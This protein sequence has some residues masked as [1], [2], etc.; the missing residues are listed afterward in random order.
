MVDLHLFSCL[1]IIT[2]VFPTPGKRR[3][4]RSSLFQPIRLLECQS[5]IYE[6]SDDC[7]SVVFL[8]FTH[9]ELKILAP[10]LLRITDGHILNTFKAEI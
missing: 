9:I 3:R 4:I 10:W 8:M 6:Y 5:Q 2:A 1:S 7:L